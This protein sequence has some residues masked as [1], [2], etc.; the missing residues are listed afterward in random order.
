[1]SNVQKAQQL[2]FQQIKERLPQHLSLVEEVE[3]LLEISQDSAYRRI[4]GEKELSLGE[5]QK[6]MGHFQV[7][8]DFALNATSDNEVNFKYNALNSKTFNLFDYVTSAYNSIKTFSSHP[9]LEMM[10]ACKDIPIFHYFM[11]DELAAFKMFVWQKTLLGFPEFEKENFSL[12]KTDPQLLEV[13]KKFLAEYN[14]FPS[15]ELWNE[16]TISSI[17]HQIEFYSEAGLFEKP[18]EAFIILDKLEEYLKHISKQ[19]ELGLKFEVGKEPSVNAKEF[20]LYHNEVVRTDNTILALIG[21][22]KLTYLTHCAINFLTTTNEKFCNVTH[23]WMSN[24]IKRSSLISKVSEKQRNQFFGALFSQL[25]K[26]RERV[27]YL[28]EH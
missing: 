12:D 9:Q 22:K 19:A 21:E 5:L 28:L 10:Y 18:E 23:D 14:K 24:L 27:K 1:M 3:E 13:G 15:S 6:L 11:I 4:R 20:R 17:L 16:D 2:F 25:K 7:S 26:T 8:A